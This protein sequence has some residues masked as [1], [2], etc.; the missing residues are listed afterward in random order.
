MAAQIVN[1][2]S[3]IEPSETMRAGT[4]HACVSNAVRNISLGGNTDA[5]KKKRVL[6]ELASVDGAVVFNDSR[7]IAF[8]AMIKS[9]EEVGSHA[10]ARTTAAVSAFNWGGH[11][12]KVSSDGEATV[13]F[14]STS[15]DGESVCNAQLTFV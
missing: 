15:S 7:I 1:R 4:P 11:P 12:V 3:I 5:I 6:V 13:Y 10:G 2:D 9:H 14:K 8:G